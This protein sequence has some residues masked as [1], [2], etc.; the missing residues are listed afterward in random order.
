MY[1]IKDHI[2]K[3]QRYDNSNQYHNW[4]RT[5]NKMQPSIEVHPSVISKSQIQMQLKSTHNQSNDATIKKMSAQKYS[6]G[7]KPQ[8][9]NAA[10]KNVVDEIPWEKGK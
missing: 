8:F 2:K 9:T 4:G 6:S 1:T 5:D 7:T 10:P 3:S